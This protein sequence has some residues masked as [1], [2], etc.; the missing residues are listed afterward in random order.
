MTSPDLRAAAT[1]R[2]VAIVALAVAG[3]LSLPPNEPD[4][5]ALYSPACFDTPDTEQDP[6]GR[7]VQ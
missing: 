3:W 4:V 5:P 7:Y 6:C 2:I 1:V